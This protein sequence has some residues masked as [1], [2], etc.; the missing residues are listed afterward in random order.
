MKTSSLLVKSHSFRVPTR[1]NAC[2]Q[3]NNGVRWFAER[4]VLSIVHRETETEHLNLNLLL[5]ISRSCP[6]HCISG[7]L[8][9]KRQTTAHKFFMQ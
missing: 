6:P 9:I 1:M 3:H 7:L 8:L 4:C 2:L 5:C